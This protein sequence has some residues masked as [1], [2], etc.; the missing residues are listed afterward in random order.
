M[1]IV[2]FDLDETLGYFVE[3]GIFWNCLSKYLYDTTKYN[4]TQLDFNEILD[5]YPEFLR[6]NI[7]AIL[8]YLKHKKNK[9]CC[10][11]IMIYTNNQGP[12]TWSEQII[13]Y[14]E[15]KIN[16]KLFDQIIAAFKI[17]GKA[18]E[19]CRTTHDKTYND[20]IK[21]T[22]IPTNAQICFLDDNYFPEMS[23]NNVYY[24]N[25]KPYV[26]NIGF[27]TILNRFMSS[28]IGSLLMDNN[29][30]NGILNCLNNYYYTYIEKT[31][32]EQEIDKIL[33]KQIMIHLQ[34]FFNKPNKNKYQNKKTNR[35]SNQIT[36]N[37]TKRNYNH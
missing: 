26:H 14:F 5:L 3:F 22:K 2:I 25:I 21:C 12:K 31:P 29:N 37:K 32:Q 33:S 35:K 23:H 20:L 17:N 15:K 16:S 7:I 9:K 27:E 6:P 4:L 18:I 30:G 24:I 11:K 36:T 28:N 13:S 19:I 34:Y 10:N 1:K 8:N